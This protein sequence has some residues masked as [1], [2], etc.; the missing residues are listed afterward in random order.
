MPIRKRTKKKSRMDRIYSD[1]RKW[2]LADPGNSRC[3]VAESGLI[4]NEEGN[5]RPHF[6]A[7][8]QVHH[9]RGRGRLYL[10][11]LTWLGV[12]A[13]GHAWIHANVKESYSRGWM[14]SREG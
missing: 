12:S 9:K 5:L 8:V 1:K 11:E 13:E 4:V 10:D 3:P 6:R 14:L 2:F 7:S